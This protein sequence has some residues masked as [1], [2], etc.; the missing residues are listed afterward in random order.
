MEFS[1]PIFALQVDSPPVM[2]KFYCSCASEGINREPSG[3]LSVDNVQHQ[4]H[5]ADLS[6]C[7]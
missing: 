2:L 4:S 6:S 3:K 7:Q 1:G 5:G